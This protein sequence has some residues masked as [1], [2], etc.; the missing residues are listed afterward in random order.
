M[1]DEDLLVGASWPIFT[2]FADERDWYQAKQ[3]K[4]KP[5]LYVGSCNG[6]TVREVTSLGVNWHIEL[7]DDVDGENEVDK[8]IIVDVFP[9]FAVRHED[10]L[11]GDYERHEDLVD[12]DYRRIDQVD[13][14][15]GWEEARGAD[16]GFYIPLDICLLILQNRF[17]LS[18]VILELGGEHRVHQDGLIVG[19]LVCQIA[20]R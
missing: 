16:L 11:E 14:S 13:P 15:K 4:E 7:D 18:F 2:I 3:V 1:L 12:Q 10:Q 6:F 19:D 17:K 5:R 9:R 20:D 8:E